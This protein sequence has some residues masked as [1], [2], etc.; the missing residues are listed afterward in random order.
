MCDIIDMLCLVFHRTLERKAKV[1]GGHT[2][3]YE[4]EAV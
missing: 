1:F 2:D 4:L 3:K